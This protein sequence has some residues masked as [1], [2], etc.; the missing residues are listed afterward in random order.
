[1]KEF[2]DKMVAFFSLSLSETVRGLIA[3]GVPVTYGMY[4]EADAIMMGVMGLF[5]FLAARLNVGY[6]A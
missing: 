4:T 3:A 1:M 6:R 2:F 5:G